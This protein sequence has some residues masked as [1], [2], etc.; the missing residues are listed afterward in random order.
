MEDICVYATARTISNATIILSVLIF[1]GK[2]PLPFSVITMNKKQ[3]SLFLEKRCAFITN[4]CIESYHNR[5][6]YINLV[7]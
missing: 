3:L 7:A 5:L 4:N 1:Q 6:K 2:N